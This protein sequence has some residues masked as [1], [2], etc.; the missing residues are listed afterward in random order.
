MGVTCPGHGRAVSCSVLTGSARLA[1]ANLPWEGTGQHSKEQTDGS[2]DFIKVEIH[3]KD[4][5]S[6]C[7]VHQVCGVEELQFL[8]VF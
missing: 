2:A 3:W 7:F 6:L 8:T 1:S 4:A 5:L